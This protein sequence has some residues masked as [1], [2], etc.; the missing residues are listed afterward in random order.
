MRWWLGWVKTCGSIRFRWEFRSSAWR[1]S[2][3]S[4]PKCMRGSCGKTK[5]GQEGWHGSDLFA[6]REGLCL[7]RAIALLDEHL[8]LAFGRIEFLF[9]GCRKSD[10]LFEELERVFEAQVAFLQLIDEAFKLFEGLFKG[11]HG[12]YS[13]STLAWGSSGVAAERRADLHALH[14]G[15]NHFQHFLGNLDTLLTCGIGGVCLGHAQHD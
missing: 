5:D 6:V 2:I 12:D 13:L 4:L 1:S 10:T 15:T 11:R 7:E 8:D 3:R 14:Q 9:A